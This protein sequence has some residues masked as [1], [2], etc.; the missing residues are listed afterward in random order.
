[1]TP[2]PQHLPRAALE[3][4]AN[5]V[6]ITDAHGTILWVNAAFTRMTGYAL[7]EVIG[8]NPRL[9]KS[10]EH[11]TVFYE[12]LWATIVSGNSWTGEMT[13]RRKDGST[14]VEEQTITPVRGAGGMISHFIAVKQDRTVRRR[15]DEALRR[16]EERYRLLAEHISDVIGLYD[17]G[18]NTV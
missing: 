5:G 12:G 14:Y 7:D 10:G 3:A 8:K 4:V 18:L 1:M 6:V 15:A 9:L 13:N 16:S 2:L 11:P 17:L